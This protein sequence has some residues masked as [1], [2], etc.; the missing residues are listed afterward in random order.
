[1]Q[2]KKG[3][4]GILGRGMAS[5]PPKIRLWG[6]RIHGRN[7]I[8]VACSASQSEVGS[9]LIIGLKFDILRMLIVV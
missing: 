8:S 6:R 2:G 9:S 5:L 3:D 7:G 4:F 1:V